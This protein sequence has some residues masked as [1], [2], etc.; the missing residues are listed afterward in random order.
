MHVL[1]ITTKMLTMILDG[2]FSSFFFLTFL[3]DVDECAT[4]LAKFKSKNYS[5]IV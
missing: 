2:I 1:A 5:L 3:L 4:L